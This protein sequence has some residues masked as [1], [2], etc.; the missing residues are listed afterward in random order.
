MAGQDDRKPDGAVARAEAAP[1]EASSGGG[2][3]L[4]IGW[5]QLWILAG[6]LFAVV[7]LDQ[8]VHRTAFSAL[9][10]REHHANQLQ[11]YAHRVRP[12]PV[13]V[14][15]VG[16]SRVLAGMDPRTIE[17]FV[18]HEA[19]PKRVARLTQQG[20]GGWMLWQLVRDHLSVAPPND[21]LVIGL[22]ERLFYVLSFETDEP[23]GLRMLGHSRDVFE[24]R[25][26]DLTDKEWR[27]LA[28][29]PLRG[30]QAPWLL[31]FLLERDVG[32]FVTHLHETGGAAQ[33]PFR[34]ITRREFQFAVRL[35]QEIRARESRPEDKPF[36]QLEV[37]AFERTLDLLETLPCR[38]V[39]VRMPVDRDYERE[40]AA[41]I[42]RFEREI[43]AKVL[44]R[45]FPYHDLNRHPEL[46]EQRV[47]Q[48]PT[49]VNAEGMAIAS[50]RLGVEVLYPLLHG[51]P[52]PYAPFLDAPVPREDL[53][54]EPDAEVFGWDG[55][56]EDD[57]EALRQRRARRAAEQDR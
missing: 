2:V 45:G 24:I 41:Q 50:R 3:G 11:L 34:P 38:V 23:L 14:L 54:A 1:A 26:A 37:E 16:S 36:R 51:A 31:P 8:V 35:G 5:G 43:V 10:P 56:D 57:R 49:H 25:H 9:V 22:E 15:V 44:A 46:R 28:L 21:L 13:D 39:F 27:A 18:W 29:A 19:D 7:T 48:N 12:E 20:M 30:L 52:S 17:R 33:R 32:E 53:P 4:R 55:M 47:F 40:E 42:R 6:F